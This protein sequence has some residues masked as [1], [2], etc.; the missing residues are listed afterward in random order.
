MHKVYLRYCTMAKI[1]KQSAWIVPL[2]KS[3]VVVLH[4]N[5]Q[6]CSSHLRGHMAASLTLLICNQVP[7]SIYKSLHRLVRNEA[8][9]TAATSHCPLPNLL[10]QSSLCSLCAFCHCSKFSNVTTVTIFCSLYGWF[11]L[12]PPPFS[13]LLSLYAPKT[14][15]RLWHLT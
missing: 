15:L 10:I 8:S 1:I 2:V 3:E 12:L 11:A 13:P 5:D 4:Q 6:Q 14:I 7:H 9:I